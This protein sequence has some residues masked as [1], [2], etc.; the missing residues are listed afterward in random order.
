MGFDIDIEGY[1]DFE[2]ILENPFE[3]IKYCIY[4]CLNRDVRY[5]KVFREPDY[6]YCDKVNFVT[7][8]I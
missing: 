5:V 1:S 7:M 6:K 8:F 3:K 4:K 2:C